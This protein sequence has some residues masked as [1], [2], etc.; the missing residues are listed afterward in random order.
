[1]ATRHVDAQFLHIWHNAYRHLETDPAQARYM[2]QVEA[3]PYAHRA[4]ELAME[5]DDPL[6]AASA[7]I[8]EHMVDLPPLVL[9][10][11]GFGPAVRLVADPEADLDPDSL[12][13]LARA[14]L[15]AVRRPD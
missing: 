14:C 5:R 2:T 15:R 12:E 11:L 3:S 7:H 6:V 4:H 8:A 9:W 13:I 10:D 1:M